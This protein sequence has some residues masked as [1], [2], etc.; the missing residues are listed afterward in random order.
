MFWERDLFL[1]H[2]FALAP[3]SCDRTCS[4]SQILNRKGREELPL[5]TPRNSASEN[6]SA[7]LLLLA[8]QNDL[9]RDAG[10]LN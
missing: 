7:K 1:S 8:E 3:D 6:C 2:F 9:A 4:K 10:I 5:R